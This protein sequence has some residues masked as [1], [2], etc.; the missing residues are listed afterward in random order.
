MVLGLRKCFGAASAAAAGKK[1]PPAQQ[2]VAGGEDQK[3]QQ[4]AGDQGAADGAETG[5]PKMVVDRS[6]VVKDKRTPAPPVVMHQFP[7]QSRPVL[8]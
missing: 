7:F 1:L 8:L 6:M 5:D 3:Q 4:A 2:L